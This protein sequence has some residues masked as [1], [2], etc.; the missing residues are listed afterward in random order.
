MIDIHAY[1]AIL[2]VSI[3]CHGRRYIVGL[4]RMLVRTLWPKGTMAWIG[5]PYRKRPV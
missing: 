1:L 5:I 3:R 4:E 2:I